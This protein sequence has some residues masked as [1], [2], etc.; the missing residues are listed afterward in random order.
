MHTFD[1]RLR[2]QVCQCT[3]AEVPFHSTP[4]VTTQVHTSPE[5][6]IHLSGNFPSNSSRLMPFA[7]LG[8]FNLCSWPHPSRAR[9]DRIKSFLWW[10]WDP[11]GKKKVGERVSRN[12]I[13]GIPMGDEHSRQL[14]FLACVGCQSVREA[15]KTF[16]RTFHPTHPVTR[17][18]R[19]RNGPMPIGADN[20]DNGLG[21]HTPHGPSSAIQHPD[22]N[23]ITPSTLSPLRTYNHA[24]PLAPTSASCTFNQSPPRAEQR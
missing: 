4:T 14:C 7:E 16:P 20:D 15:P 6:L 13:D 22:L 24:K 3:L 11:I 9:A 17:P 10:L 19:G 8:G 18:E 12:N 21:D 23:S 2:G 5:N 1:H